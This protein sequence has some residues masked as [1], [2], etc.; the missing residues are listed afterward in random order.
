[1]VCL[2]AEINILLLYTTNTYSVATKADK[3]VYETEQ[4]RPPTEWRAQVVWPF[5]R[6][7]NI[8]LSA[9][10]SVCR[11]TTNT[12][13]RRRPM[14]WRSSHV[15]QRNE[16]RLFADRRITYGGLCRRASSLVAMAALLQALNDN[17]SQRRVSR[18]RYNTSIPPPMR[19]DK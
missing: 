18:W 11:R 7:R 17:R 5:R 16:L 8:L 14:K 3:F 6:T 10:N 13:C 12:L 15:V 2:L 19:R 9:S 4:C 1:M